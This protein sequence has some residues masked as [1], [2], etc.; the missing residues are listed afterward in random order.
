VVPSQ[1][2]ESSKAPAC[3]VQADDV[4]QMK[5]GRMGL[6]RTVQDDLRDFRDRLQAELKK[7]H[8]EITLGA[9]KLLRT[10]VAAMAMAR[11]AQG[12]L[13]AARQGRIK[14]SEE[15][16]QGWADRL[17]KFEEKADATLAKLGIRLRPMSQKEKEDA[18]W[19]QVYK[20][21][22]ALQEAHQ[23][24]PEGEQFASHP[25][26]SD[27]AAGQLAQQEGNGDG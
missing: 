1:R 2:A 20:P 13:E 11:K 17:V 8:G 22:P 16:E 4:Y 25:A 15:Q 10:A 5:L 24:G 19:A 23:V 26:G 12:K 27:G 3:P 7:A 14:L 9:S 18:L 21:V 6:S